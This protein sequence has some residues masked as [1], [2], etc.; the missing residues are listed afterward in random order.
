MSNFLA[1]L[2][3]YS[4]TQFSEP[5]VFKSPNIDLQRKAID[6]RLISLRGKLC[7]EIFSEFTT[8][9]GYSLTT[10]ITKSY[11]LDIS[12]IIFF[13]I[14]SLRKLDSQIDLHFL[15]ILWQKYPS[16]SFLVESIYFSNTIEFSLVAEKIVAINSCIKRDRSNDWLDFVKKI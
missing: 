12:G 4:E 5:G 16:I 3:T 15:N 11:N 8:E 6:S 7:G 2:H 9:P 13:T 14:D 1:V 10:L